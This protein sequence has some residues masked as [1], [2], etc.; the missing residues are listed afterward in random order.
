MMADAEFALKITLVVFMIGNLLDMGLRLKLEEA[1]ADLRDTRFVIA[2][3][4]WGFLLLPVIAFG[5]ARLLQLAHPYAAGLLLLAMAPCAPFLPP[6][7]D[8]ARGDLGYT[9][10]FMLLA[11]VVTVVYLPLAVPYAVPGL[12]A[13]AS[14]IAKPLVLFVLVPLAVGAL[15][16]R[17]SAALADRMHPVVKKVT[18]IDTLAMLIL[19]AV[20]Y[21]QGFEALLGSHAI[22]AQLLFFAAATALPYIVGFGLEQS[23][24]VVLSL[25][26]STR[27]LG[28]AFAPLFAAAS[29][30]QRAVVMVALGVVMQATFA[31]AAASYFRAT[32]GRPAEDSPL[33]KGAP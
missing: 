25:G 20:V 28:A 33:G 5:I 27:N 2:S 7:V 10:A 17:A 15:I 19:C 8:R 16:R 31:F 6:M 1:L 26:M 24:R 18:S 22:G 21:G 4:A 3:L 23:K 12:S 29:V 9:A 13:D 14:T 30:D 11:S 32:C